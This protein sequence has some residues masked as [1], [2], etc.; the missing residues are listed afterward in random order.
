M[1]L[2]VLESLDLYP[3]VLPLVHRFRRV[4]EREIVLIQGPGGWGEFS[5]FPEYPPSVTSRWLAAALEL[6]C[7][8]LPD[9]IH[10]KV[11]VNVTIPAVPPS[12]ATELVKSSG[13][14]TAKVKVADPGQEEADDLERVAAVR[15]ALGPKGRIRVDVNGVWDVDTAIA[16]IL[17]LSE[18]TLEYVEQP[19]TSP[20]DLA[21]VRS[22]TGV[23]I[24]IDE[25]LRTATDPR[26][27]IESANADVIVVKVQPLGGV[28]R[29]LD[30]ARSSG[31]PVV[32]SSAVESSIG[33]FAGVLA[34]ACLEELP[35][36]CGLGTVSLLKD[37]VTG[38]RLVPVD[39]FL[40]V[41]RPVPDPDL[42]ARLR[43][44]NERAGDMLRRVRAAAE[45]LT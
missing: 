35:Y 15:E 32:V 16:R 17:R 33:M 40:P 12:I 20:S 25:S 13:C 7:S 22:E 30:L 8:A 26:Q 42:V 19:V 28:V 31:V 3:V 45:L 38:D 9:P 24:A 21:R 39:G 5:P 41:R 6:A 18:F 34:A 2:H 36:A 4:H 14:S 37:D 44:S 11:P 29:T 1:S 27:V 43:P 23:P 10:A